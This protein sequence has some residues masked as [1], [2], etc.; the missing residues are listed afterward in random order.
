[1]KTPEDNH[2][3]ER[4]AVSAPRLLDRSFI[5]L[6]FT[7]IIATS[8][9]LIAEF[10]TRSVPPALVAM[11][12][13][14][15]LSNLGAIAIPA[16]RLRAPWFIAATIVAD[17]VW[18]TIAL[19]AT[20]RFTSEFFYLYFFVI[21]LAGVGENLR[22]IALGVTVVCVAYVVLAA[23]TVGFN[24]VVSTQTLIRVPFLFSVAIFYGYLVDRLRKERHQL[25]REQAVSEGLERNR[26]ALSEAN[27]E[28]R[29]LSDVKSKFVSTVSH[30]LK[31]PL[32][33]I[34][35]AVSLIEPGA[36]GESQVK[37]LEMIR[38]NADRLNIII[39]DLLDMSKAES[40]SLTI[41]AD[42]LDLRS[43]LSQVMEPFKTQAEGAGIGISIEI[44]SP[45]SLQPVF[46]DANRIE[47][48]VANL[49]SNALKATPKG[50][51]ITLTVEDGGSEWVT[52]TVTDDGVGLSAEDQTKVFE[53]FFQAE[54]TLEGKPAG[55][56]LGLTICRDL[57]RGHGSELRLESEPGVGSSFSFSLPVLSDRARET[58]A[59][60][61]QVRTTYRA[62]PYFAVLIVD[63]G[64]SMSSQPAGPT[65]D[66][67]RDRLAKLLPR[68]LDVL[69]EQPAHGR[70]V[71][72]MLSTPLGGGWVVKRKLASA[73][74]PES[75]G[76]NTSRMGSFKVLGPAGFPEDGEHGSILIGRAFDRGEQLEEKS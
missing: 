37:F 53:P 40:G 23:R 73:F 29:R 35:N 12:I 75:L 62:H 19:I 70:I 74:A 18:I 69:C 24:E 25:S 72:V 63:G 41:A 20:G 61:N 15:L 71:V 66:A 22:L 5:L 6:R 4:P 44:E 46:A 52:I 10:G 8:Y 68:E 54:N 65:L 43:F 45:E 14:V 48:V 7:L 28:L 26:R 17:T 47:Q 11:M 33:A 49:L 76:E 60:E 32:T 42:S 3:L 13:V 9:L 16:A 2:W 56:G 27:E 38:R 39:A 58:I 21:F 64:Q 51:S 1:M 36:D 50:G 67:A 30:E 57:V 55:T 59:F 34:K 31:S